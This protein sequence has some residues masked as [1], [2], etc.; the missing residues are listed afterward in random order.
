MNNSRARLV[1]LLLGAPEVLESAEGSQDGTTDPDRVFSLRGSDD[2][3][4]HARGREGSQ[5]LLHTIGDTREHGGSSR[6]D[7]VAVQIATNIQIALEDRVVAAK[8]MISMR[9]TSFI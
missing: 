8:L 9:S 6:E 3:D 4:L 7:D 5:L 1:V 2:L